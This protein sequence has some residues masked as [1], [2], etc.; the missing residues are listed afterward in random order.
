LSPP[1]LGGLPTSIYLPSF[2]IV[3]DKLQARDKFVTNE[4]RPNP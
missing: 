3:G 1:A 4:K 2:E